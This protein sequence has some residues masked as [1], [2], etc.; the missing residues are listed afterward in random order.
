MYLRLQDEEEYHPHVPYSTPITPGGSL[1]IDDTCTS[2]EVTFEDLHSAQRDQSKPVDALNEYLHSR[3][4]SPIRSR[5]NT[6]WEIASER[7]RRY[8]IRKAGQGVTAIMGDI[9][10][11]SPAQLFQATCSSQAI[12]RTLSSD[13]ET[14][15]TVDETMLEALA[16]CYHAAGSWE[17]RRQILS[18]MADKLS[19]KKLKRWIP[20]LSNYRF[21]EAKRHCLMHGRGAPVPSASA[22][23][24]RFSTTQIDHFISFITCTSA[25][26]IQELPFGERTITLSS[27]E[28]IKVPN[29]IR[30]MVPERIV[31]QYL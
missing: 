4:A 30:T 13:E 31:K 9:A 1:Y 16:D 6:P 14:E 29:V 17:T 26:V 23:V 12:Q 20:D 25:H 19:F 10:P 28:T 15:T 11:N 5:L 22:P 3:D 24:M 18:I 21:T 27:R 8:Y 7:T 2:C